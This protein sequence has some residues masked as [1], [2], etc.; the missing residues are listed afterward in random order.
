MV[1]P[2]SYELRICDALGQHLVVNQ[3]RLLQQRSHFNR[4]HAGK[5][6]AHGETYKNVFEAK[7]VLFND[8]THLAV[9]CGVFHKFADFPAFDVR[10]KALIS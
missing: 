10:C 2:G 8:W 7:V 4:V 9:V 1:G 3:I 6:V 5:A